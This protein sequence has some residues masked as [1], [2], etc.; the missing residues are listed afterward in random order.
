MTR[1]QDLLAILEEDGV[2][3]AIQGEL[4]TRNVHRERRAMYIHDVLLDVIVEAIP[5]D[6]LS[7]NKER[8]L[9]TK[10][11]KQRSENPELAHQGLYHC[12]LDK[13]LMQI[14]KEGKFQNLEENDLG[15]NSTGRFE[16]KLGI[17]GIFCTFGTEYKNSVDDSQK[18]ENSNMV[19]FASHYMNDPSTLCLELE[20][21]STCWPDLDEDYLNEHFFEIAEELG[22]SL[23]KEEEWNLTDEEQTQ[24]LVTGL[25]WAM[26]YLTTPAE[27]RSQKEAIGHNEIVIRAENLIPQYIVVSEDAGFYRDERAGAFTD[28]PIIELGTIKKAVD[29]AYEN[30]PL[31]GNNF[32]DNKVY[33]SMF[34]SAVNEG[35]ISL[36]DLEE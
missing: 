16:R 4:S 1:Y 7:N 17:T 32:K 35:K 2:V 36:S 25:V 20:T 12:V 30:V 23:R 3:E 24:Y 28:V 33:R 14:L 15:P 19:I 6:Y 9:A 10:P 27:I 34:V 21:N 8:I 29:E 26:S 13:R 11:E 22:Y 18:E 5:Q 31:L